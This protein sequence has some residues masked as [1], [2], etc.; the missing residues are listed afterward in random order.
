MGNLSA[1]YHSSSSAA[2]SPNPDSQYL[3]AVHDMT[4]IFVDDP[5]AHASCSIQSTRRCPVD[6]RGAMEWFLI[7][8]T[9]IGKRRL[10]WNSSKLCGI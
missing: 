9:E 5:A 8:S 6:G 7:G 2:A 3:I 10:A 4:A 1:H